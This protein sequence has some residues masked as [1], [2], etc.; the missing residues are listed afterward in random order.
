MP[1]IDAATDSQPQQHKRSRS[2]VLRSFVAPGSKKTGASSRAQSQSP[3]KKA[4]SER[5][6]SEEAKLSSAPPLD[7]PYPKAPLGEI[8][9]LQ[10]RRSSPR[11]QQ[12]M[13]EETTRPLKSLHKKNKSAVSLKSLTGKGKDKDKDKS[14]D[15]PS[16]EDARKSCDE[17]RPKKSKSSTSLSALLSRPK[18]SKGRKHEDPFASP[19]KENQ[20]P[21]KSTTD[22]QPPPIW[23]QFASPQTEEVTKT[24]RIPLNDSWKFSDEIDRYTPQEY[25]PSKGRNFHES[26][27]SLA[28]KL[29]PKS[30]AVDSSAARSLTDTFSRLG[31]TSTSSTSAS[32]PGKEN[33]K[34]DPKQQRAPISQQDA[35]R[36]RAISD[37]GKS[38]NE[39]IDPHKPRSKVMAAVAAFDGKSRDAA[40]PPTPQESKL[41]PAAVD[42]AF[43]AMLEARNTPGDVRQ[44][45]RGLDTKLKSEF[46]RQNKSSDN[47]VDL[48]KDNSRPGTGKRSRTDEAQSSPVEEAGSPKKSRPRSLTFTRSKDTSPT[49]KQKSERSTS[50]HSR[51]KSADLVR[52][53]SSPSLA[54]SGGGVGL[55]GR[56]NKPAVPED[57]IT[58]LRK[59]QKP[60]LVEVGRLQ[61]LRQLLRNETVS[62]TDSFITQ[63]GMDE[64]VSLL[65][66]VMDI[67]WRCVQRTTI[68]SKC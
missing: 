44:K 68:P 15:K 24:T 64:I 8:N 49:K 67:E 56:S 35:A 32:G 54:S 46:I 36:Q 40:L 48:G 5:V 20:S 11:K 38:N 39:N 60:Q 2:A 22:S 37:A 47:L 13:T 59:V 52:T 34:S 14:K 7:F 29:R 31:R 66:R 6:K 51:T 43:E 17:S 63:G 42:K 23:A 3:S 53:T 30:A 21:H 4:F 33:Q 9:N 19:D 12:E 16:R 25:S 1:L 61:K 57:F 50:Q 41:D 62:W 26:E 55:F 58:Y 28:R 45:M 65:R 10:G 18:S 27:P